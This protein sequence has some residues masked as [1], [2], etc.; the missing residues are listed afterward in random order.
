VARQFGEGGGRE[1]AGVLDDA[2]AALKSAGAVL[3]EV[4]IP[5]YSPEP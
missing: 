3:V 5:G 2:L 1:L 4:T